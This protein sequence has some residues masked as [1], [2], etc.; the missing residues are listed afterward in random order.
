M[1]YNH[2]LSDIALLCFPLLALMLSFFNQNAQWGINSTI[3]LI[4]ST[5]PSLLLTSYE[6]VK[7]LLKHQVGV[8]VLAII[9]MSGALWMGESAT[10]AVI[11]A[12]TATGRL[13]E[14]YAQG[15]AEREMTSL[16]SKA[17][18][19]ANR[20]LKNDIQVIPVESIQPGDLLLVKPG[21]T[22]P[23]TVHW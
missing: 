2:L 23:V 4:L 13:L 20:L 19:S 11:A 1:K 16:L 10:A 7:S 17:P 5:L 9:S 6:M 21:E 8:D 22:I 14:S 15:R 3:V 18:R 12:M